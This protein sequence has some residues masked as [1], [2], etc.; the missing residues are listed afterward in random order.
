MDEVSDYRSLPPLGIGPI[1]ASTEST[2]Q[3]YT[4]IREDILSG[5]LKANQRVVAT[6]LT[7][8]RGSQGKVDRQPDTLAPSHFQK[9]RQGT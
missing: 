6:D 2:A 4:A 9:R 7:T 1:G 3:L 8:R 5:R